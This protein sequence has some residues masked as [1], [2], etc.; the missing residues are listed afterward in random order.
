MR[1][2][3]VERINIRFAVTWDIGTRVCGSGEIHMELVKERNVLVGMLALS[4]VVIFITCWF[5][6]MVSDP[7][8]VFGANYLSDLG[9]SKYTWAHKFF[10]GGCLIA[11]VMLA[12]CGTALMISKKGK[13]LTCAGLFA[14][15]SGIS[16]AL[17]GIVTED[18]GDPHIWIAMCA[19]GFGF[20]GLML[21]AIRDW[22][23]GLKILAMLTPV[24]IMAVVISCLMFNLHVDRITPEVETVAIIVLLA[25][26]LL[27]GMKFVYHGAADLGR[28]CIAG[29]HKLA[30]GFA[31]LLASVAFLA[32]WMFAA[33]SDPSWTFGEDHVYMLGMSAVSETHMF[34]GLACL[35]GGLFAII[36]GIGAGLMR[37]GTLRSVGCFFIVIA[38]IVVTGIGMTLSAEKEVYLCA[39]Q[40]AIAFGMI[41]LMLIVASDWIRKRMIPAAFYMVVLVCGSVSLLIGYDGGAA[42]SILA[43]FAVLGI[44]GIR[45]LV[46]K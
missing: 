13:I 34:F 33:L 10:N 18:A 39:E 8:W 43:L 40:W 32:L 4:A 20:L 27:Q 14:L 38:S 30:F 26:F 36:Y 25:L 12:L 21:F 9:V 28:P 46:S 29:R 31:A 23:D 2:V 3:C 17:I 5:A 11:G 7:D 42:F 16:M 37:E 6:A 24:G 1:I 19:F 45:L 15:I 22:D 35:F 44:E 41:A